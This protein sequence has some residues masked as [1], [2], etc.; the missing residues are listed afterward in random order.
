MSKRNEKPEGDVRMRGFARRHTVEAALALLDEQLQPL[1]AALVARQPADGRLLADAIAS[2]VDVPGFDRATVDGYAVVADSTDGATSYA[3]LPLMVI[4]DS[5]PGRPFAGSVRAG[6]AVRIMT[7]APLPSGCNA[8]LPAEFVDTTTDARCISA[9]A[10]VSP[11]KHV[12]RRGEDVSRGTTIL[13]RGRTL[14]PQDLGVLSSIGAG[15]VRVFR[16]PRVRLVITGNELLPV[17]SLP[18]GHSIVDAKGPMLAAL[19]GRPHEGVAIPTDRRD[20]RPQDQLSDWP[21]R[22]CARPDRRRPCR[23]N[24]HRRC[25]GAVLDHARRRL[26]RRACRQ[27]GLCSRGRGEGL[28]LCVIRSSSFTCSIATK[29]SVGFERRSTRRRAASKAFR[30]MRP[31]AACWRPTS[32]RRSMCRRSTARMW[33]ASLSRPTAPSVHPKSCRGACSSLTKRYI[34][35]LSRAPQSAA[36]RLWRLRREG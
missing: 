15:L 12:G 9:L 32:S 14:R 20:T 31:S 2:D 30:S 3:P 34:R 26:R 8:V 21:S 18:S 22:L 10:A 24:R 29:P 27:R 36:D 35:E 4:G 1:D 28:D 7:G 13:E 6:Q 5:L 19:S 16:K 17:G 23:A 33:T 25:I 11:G